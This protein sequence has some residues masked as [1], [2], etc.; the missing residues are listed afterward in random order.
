MRF[1]LMPRMPCVYRGL[2]GKRG[3][4]RCLFCSQ[5]G[6]GCHA[7]QLWSVSNGAINVTW[8]AI[9]GKDVEQR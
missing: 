3:S 9:H 2:G 5:Y 8:K 6:V 1:L 4:E 7:L